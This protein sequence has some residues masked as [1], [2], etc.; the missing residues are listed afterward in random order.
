MLIRIVCSPSVIHAFNGKA[1]KEEERSAQTPLL[2]KNLLCNPKRTKIQKRSSGN[3]FIDIRYQY[4]FESANRNIK[5]T[6][7]R[8][9]GVEGVSK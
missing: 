2:R 8:G 3:M 6:P 7:A 4:G 5:K 9:L 1:R